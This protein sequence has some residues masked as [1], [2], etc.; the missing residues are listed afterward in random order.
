[1]SKK[2]IIGIDINEVLR[3]RWIQF[4]RYYVEEFG[5]EGVPEMAY[6]YD[7]WNTYK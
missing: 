3:Y 2:K 6:V 7:F 4:D 5:E 1:M